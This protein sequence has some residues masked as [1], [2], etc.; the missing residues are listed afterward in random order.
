LKVVVVMGCEKEE[1]EKKKK[2]KKSFRRKGL[3]Q[4]RS[5]GQGVVLLEDW[6]WGGRS[7][8]N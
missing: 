5:E 1:E 3:L 7:R 4:G 6:E 8:C 2:K